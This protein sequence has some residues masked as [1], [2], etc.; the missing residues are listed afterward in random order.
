TGSGG[1]LGPNG[2]R[3]GSPTVKERSV[4]SAPSHSPSAMA[5]SSISRKPSMVLPVPRNA[6][7]SH[8]GVHD[9]TTPVRLKVLAATGPAASS[10]AAARLEAA[11]NVLACMALVPFAWLSK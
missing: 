9:V 2:G 3:A 11:H 5:A 7:V 8:V 10:S 6:K 1:S 4:T